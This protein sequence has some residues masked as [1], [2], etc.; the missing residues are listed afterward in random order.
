MGGTA[1]RLPWGACGCF[2][3]GKLR[4]SALWC[5]DARWRRGPVPEGGR[6]GKGQGGGFLT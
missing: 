5:G 4:A 3:A 2:S 6:Y 1:V